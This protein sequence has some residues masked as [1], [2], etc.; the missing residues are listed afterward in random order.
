MVF[1]FF[2][3]QVEFISMMQ[4]WFNIHTLTNVLPHINEVKAQNHMNISLDEEKA[5]DIESNNQLR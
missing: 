5:F 1:F 3:A 4:S 2:H